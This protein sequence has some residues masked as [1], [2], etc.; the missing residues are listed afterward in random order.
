MISDNGYQ[1]ETHQ[2]HTAGEML[3]AY[4][5]RL[6]IRQWVVPA[7]PYPVEQN[8]PKHPSIYGCAVYDKYGIAEQWG[9]FVFLIMDSGSI[10]CPIFGKWNNS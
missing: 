5:L 10:G 4:F 6:G 3:K 1:L 8:S 7:P 2:N 9:K